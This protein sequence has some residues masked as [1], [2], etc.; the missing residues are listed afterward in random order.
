MPRAPMGPPIRIRIKKTYYFTDCV[1]Y[2]PL[3]VGDEYD[4]EL[5]DGGMVYIRE[6]GFGR[7][8]KVPPEYY[9]KVS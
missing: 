1:H 8:V 7:A 2:D 9:E 3:A 5:L 4:G 6:K